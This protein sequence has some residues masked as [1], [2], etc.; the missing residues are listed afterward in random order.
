MA[1]TVSISGIELKNFRCFGEK[2]FEF[3]APVVFIQGNNGSGKTSILEALFYS[4]N[5]R[6]FRGN[7]PRELVRFEN[8]HFFIRVTFADSDLLQVGFADQKKRLRI[9]NNLITNYQEL[10][11]CY[12]AIAI[13]QDD[14]DIIQEYPVQRRL[15]IDQMLCQLNPELIERF[16][17]FRLAL[18][19]RNEWLALKKPIDPVLYELLTTELEK[20]SEIIRTHRIALLENIEQK[21]H[22]L[23]KGVF[24]TESRFSL[25]YKPKE[26]VDLK[27]LQ[28]Q[29][30][31]MGRSL[32]GCQLDDFII[33]INQINVRNFG[34]RGQQKAAILLLKIA[35]GI[36]LTE[37]HPRSK[38][39][40]LLDDFMTDFDETRSNL[41][42][43]LL[44]DLKMQLFFTSPVAPPSAFLSVS[45]KNIVNL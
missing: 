6:A 26:I 27:R 32:I 12:H 13:T 45:H 19:K 40:F 24:G 35:Q 10:A 30:L 4:S 36:L 34:S 1:N 8:D 5:V 3:D 25:A 23:Q 2:K 44:L 9:N 29:E 43:S 31:R 28:Q 22:P 15:F 20:Q 17:A 7:L 18:Q 37:A 33:T 39:A 38:K 41:F 42:L 21:L 14:M 11:H 16:Q